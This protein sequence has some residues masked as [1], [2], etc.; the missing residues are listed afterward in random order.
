MLATAITGGN[1]PDMADIAAPGYVKQLV[2]QG[3]LKPITYAKSAHR[4]RTSRPRGCSSGRSA[5]SSTR[6]SSR[7]RTSR[8]SGTTCRTSRRPAIKPPKTFAQLLSDAQTLKASGDAGVLD[9]RLGRLDAHRPVREHLPAHVR[10]REVQPAD[11]AQDQVDR[12]VGDHG[13]EDDGEDPRRHVEHLRRHE[14][15][16]AV[17]LQRL[18]H[19][20]VRDAVEGRDRVRGRLRLGRHPLVDEVEGRDGLQRGAVPVDHDRAPTRPRSRSAA[21]CSSP[22]A[23]TPRSRR[24]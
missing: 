8:C 2:Q 23:T 18:R 16:A 11:G 19:E 1:P 24:S 10:A 14:R 22:S 20:R 17:R 5:A 6:S 13:A 21:T 15:C 12:P 7:R 9:R 3:H 4:R